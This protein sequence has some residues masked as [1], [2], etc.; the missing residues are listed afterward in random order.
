[1][2]NLCDLFVQPAG[3]VLAFGFGSFFIFSGFYLSGQLTMT[4]D[5][6]AGMAGE[7]RSWSNSMRFPDSGP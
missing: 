6:L 1:V 5:F 7:Q 4:F 3:Q 2:F